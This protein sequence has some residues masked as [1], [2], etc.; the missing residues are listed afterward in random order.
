MKNTL[1]P[2]AIVPFKGT[3]ILKTGV[4]RSAGL[5]SGTTSVFWFVSAF[6]A[7][8]SA[9]YADTTNSGLSTFKGAKADRLRSRL[10]T[11]TNTPTARLDASQ[12]TWVLQEI[13]PDQKTW[14]NVSTN[15]SSPGGQSVGRERR[16]RHRIVEI[17]TGMNYF[18][19][20]NWV[21]SDPSFD[22]TSDAFVAQRTQHK[23]RLDAN[24][25]K[26]GAVT[27]TTPDGI[28][29]RST[30]VEIGLYDAASGQSAILAAIKDC[31]GAL[32]SSNQV[33]YENAFNENG[34]QADVIYTIK[35]ASLEQDVVFRSRLNVAD[36]GFP[37]NTTRIQI[38]TEFYGVPQPDRIVR[39]IRV[40]SDEKVRLRMAS[41]DL[42]DEILAGANLPSPLAGRGWRR[43]TFP[44]AQRR[45]RL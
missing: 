3:F 44:M 15:A 41:P 42:V 7:I 24:L 45:P 19:G 26:I 12:G 37:T 2:N 23:V 17:G 40:E 22:V 14:V 20:Q 36:Y 29:L 39:P 11:R 5:R 16:G 38:F 35:K 30:P 32:V 4:D 10:L 25:N 21:P 27:V 34:V 9:L 6:L 31:S 43:W 28:V 13:G 8:T 1:K 33:V 18:D